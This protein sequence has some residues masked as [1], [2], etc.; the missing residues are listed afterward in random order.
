MQFF[1][2]NYVASIENSKLNV[3]R[4]KLC[5]KKKNFD[6]HLR[7]MLPIKFKIIIDN[8]TINNAL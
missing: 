7:G 4:R 3:D 1:S 8:K 6:Q 2:L 5:K